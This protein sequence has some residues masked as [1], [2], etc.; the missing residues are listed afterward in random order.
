[1][2]ND[3]LKELHEGA[4][5]AGKIQINGWRP[6]SQEEK[7]KLRKKRELFCEIDKAR[8]RINYS[9]LKPSV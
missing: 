7:E 1:M 4:S 9:W 6:L 2:S 8:A 5:R 3:K